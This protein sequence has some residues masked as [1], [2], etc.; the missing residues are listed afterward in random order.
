MGITPIETGVPSDIAASAWD[1]YVA[2]AIAEAGVRALEREIAKVCRKIVKSIT[3]G[4]AE[5]GLTVGA[6]MLP[7][8]LG[9]RKYNY[10]IAE[11]ENKIGQVT[12]LAWTSV[13]G[14]LLT[15]EAVALPGKG[16]YVKTGSL[17]D[18]MQESIQ[19]AASFMRSRSIEY[20]I[21]PPV[22]ERRD[23]HVHVPEGAT[24]KDGPS[25]GV[26]MVTSIVSV[27]TGIAVRKDIAMTGEVSLRGNAM[28]IG[29][30]K[31]K[32]IA[33][34]VLTPHGVDK[35]R[36]TKPWSFSSP[37][38]AAA[39]VLDR[40]SNGRT[41]WKVKGSKQTYHDWQQAQAVMRETAK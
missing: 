34:G 20:G 13:G 17:G 38:A 11:E 32:L 7:D 5:G 24:P 8:L 9:V 41:E 27:L 26:A 15:I 19:A 25:A 39:T 40:N 35:L 23:I 12:G 14:E 29:G 2:T 37:S 33:D 6:D 18:V 31:E 21:K 22:F 3:L 4:E 10:G 28:P 30:L 1:G 36:F 16:R